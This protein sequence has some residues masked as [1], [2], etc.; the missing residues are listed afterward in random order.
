MA[1]PLTADPAASEPVSRHRGVLWV[2]GVAAI[3][4]GTFAL[5][6]PLAASIGV[7][8]AIGAMLAVL[9]VVELARAFRMRRTRR[10]VAAAL[11]GGLA[12]IAGLVL[13]F[14]PETGVI[15][16][17]ILLIAYLLAGGVLR[18]I[19]AWQARQARGAIWL[20]VSGV[21]SL[22]L[23]I[24]LWVALPGAALWALGLI[25]GI[26]VIVFGFAQIALAMYQPDH[27]GEARP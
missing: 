10:V 9:G 4:I 26:D 23:G 2:T 3:V 6:Y 11:F 22:A 15:S 12:V 25:F 7:S 24:I 16:L 20:A 5:I 8:L 18:L 17:T 13:M 19:S 14:L 21:L 27:A 1:D